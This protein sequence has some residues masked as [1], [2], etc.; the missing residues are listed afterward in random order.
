[1]H[2]SPSPSEKLTPIVAIA[3][4]LSIMGDSLMYGILA[5]EAEALGLSL[6]AVGWLLS[7]NRWIRLLSNTLA[8]RVFER[9]GP[10]LPFL[11]STVLGFVTAFLYG[12][13]LGFFVFLLAR[14]GWGI[15]WSGL[16][17][18][19]YEA[20][21]LGDP[22][23][24]GK[25]MGTLWGI[26]RLGSALSVVIGGYLYDHYGYSISVGVIT[27]FTALAIPLAYLVKWPKQDIKE[28]SPLSTTK[29][30]FDF[31]DWQAAFSTSI[32]RWLLCSALLNGMLTGVIVPT[33][34]VFIAYRLGN[35]QALF[36]SW[37]GIGTLT[38]LL[39]FTR[40]TSNLV[41][42]P[43]IGAISDRVGQTQTIVVLS[44]GAFAAV[45]A[46]IIVPGLWMIGALLCIFV[47]LAGLFVTLSAS[48]SGIATQTEHPQRFVGVYT[49]ISDIGAALGPIFAFNLVT[50]IGFE[51]IYVGLSIALLL[52]VVRFRVVEKRGVKDAIEQRKL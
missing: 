51:V 32:Q 22:Q 11:F 28:S 34:A 26:V 19:G 14:M 21:W 27:F 16:R 20:V 36:T 17:Q 30:L 31:A 37:V 12:A 43:L 1:M 4:G 48:S 8:G 50:I 41:F 9:F 7:A 13:G 46:A 42:G 25:L 10:R 29:T 47:T 3:I 23:K 18:G 2:K 33:V 44:L 49:T 40:W 45:V 24:K 5:L 52:S 35:D 6:V 38:G 15:A 39:L